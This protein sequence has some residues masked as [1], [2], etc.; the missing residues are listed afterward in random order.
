MDLYKGPDA[1]RIDF[2]FPLRERALLDSAFWRVVE[3]GH[4]VP[5]WAIVALYYTR[6]ALGPE[7]D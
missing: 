3:T 6:K 2:K 5:N 1:E 4:N 7:R